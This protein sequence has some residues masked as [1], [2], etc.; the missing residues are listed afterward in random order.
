MPLLARLR[1][2]AVIAGGADRDLRSLGRG[3]RRL[4]DARLGGDTPVVLLHGRCVRTSE[5]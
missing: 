2:S 1:E 4:L 5:S 3:A